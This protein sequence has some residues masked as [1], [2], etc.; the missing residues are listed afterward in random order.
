DVAVG[1]R[2]GRTQRHRLAGG[3][4]RR[5]GSTHGQRARGGRDGQRACRG[6][7]AALG[8]GGG[9]GGA[10]AGVGRVAARREGRRHRPGGRGPAAADGPRG[11][12]QI[13]HGKGDGALVDRVGPAG[14]IRLQGHALGR[15]GVVISYTQGRAGD[16]GLGS[17]SGH[18]QGAAG[19]AGVVIDQAV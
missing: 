17:G 8:V 14:D 13:A 3:A 15:T 11:R 12:R 18:A 9:V 2:D 1:T 5:A 16:A 4:E 6:G 19:G 10:V 7:G